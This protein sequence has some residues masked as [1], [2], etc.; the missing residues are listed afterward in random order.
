MPHDGLAGQNLK[1]PAQ[2]DQRVEAW[3][4][5]PSLEQ[6]DMRPMQPRRSRKIFL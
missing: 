2:V 5:Q 4:E 3:F 6:R 1:R